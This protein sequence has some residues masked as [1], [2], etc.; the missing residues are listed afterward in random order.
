MEAI[1]LAGGLGTRLSAIVPGLPKPMAPV[2]GQ[3][4]LQYI[5]DNLSADFTRVILS[6]GY[7]S[8]KIIEY[9]GSSY[10][11]LEL[12]YEIEESPLGTGGAINN[13]LRRCAEDHVYVL[14][15]DTY[16]SPNYQEIEALWALYENP[17][18]IGV[19]VS[20]SARYGSLKII[21][22]EV[23]G[24]NEKQ[25]NGPGIINAGCYVIPSDFMGDLG[26]NISFSMEK[27]FF[28]EYLIKNKILLYVTNSN[29]IDIGVERD[30][31][32]AQKFEFNK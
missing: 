5:L 26:R 24:L 23:V 11:N 17:I 32:L 31:L 3:P 29:F 9:F 12:I 16:I 7:Q 1:I 30:Y 8:N 15:G 22:N 18:L 27:D 6:L 2:Q 20:D 25:G 19:E 14:N 13:A 4:F 28:P 10:K 21:D